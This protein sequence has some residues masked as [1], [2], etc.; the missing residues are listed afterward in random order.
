[1]KPNFVTRDISRPGEQCHYSVYKDTTLHI[2]IIRRLVTPG[3]LNLNQIL[4]S[5]STNNEIF[6]NS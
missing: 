5:C 2:L 3:H 6:H 1:V 4:V